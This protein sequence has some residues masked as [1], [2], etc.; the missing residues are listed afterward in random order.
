[1]KGAGHEVHPNLRKRGVVAP[2]HLKGHIA[3]HQGVLCHPVGS[4]H[5]V[6][7]ILLQG[8]DED[9]PLEYV[10]GHLLLHDTE[11]VLHS[12]VDQGLHVD[13]D[14]GLRFDVEHSLPV[15]VDQDHLCGVGHGLQVD[16]H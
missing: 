1:M 12:D 9:Q 3:L 2:F 16:A 5:L 15:G 4:I 8:T 10:V 6:D 11:D 7:P 13:V 14:R